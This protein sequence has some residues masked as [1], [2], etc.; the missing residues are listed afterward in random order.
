MNIYTLFITAFLVGLSGAMMPGPLVTVALNES[1]KK[2]LGA[3]LMVSSGHAFMEA[4]LVFSLTLGLG[5][6]LSSPTIMGIIGIVGSLFLFKM[7]YDMVKDVLSGKVSL[8]MKSSN[9]T[10]GKFGPGLSGVLATVSNPYW[11]LWWVTIG[12]SYVALSIK[13]GTAGV[14]FF[15]FGHILS[16]FS[17][18]FIVGLM[19]VTGKKYISDRVYRSIIFIMGSF[20]GVLSVYFL[21][22]GIRFLA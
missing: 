13:N 3:N 9:G 12:T 8:D 18:L 22:S 21:Y 1:L 4:L 15:Y 7:A 20:L 6:I 11:F 5:S 10:S 14:L 19:V 16:D 2:G 17:W